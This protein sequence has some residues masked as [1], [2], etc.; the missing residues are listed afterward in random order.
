MSAIFPQY[1]KWHLAMMFIS[2]DGVFGE[3]RDARGVTDGRI[4]L[5]HR[6]HLSVFDLSFTVHI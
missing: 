3:E 6:C 2:V 4:H 5:H 1:Q